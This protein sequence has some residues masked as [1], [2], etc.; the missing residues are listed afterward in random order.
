MNEK[1]KDK[2][3]TLNNQA[4][5]AKK[6]IAMLLRKKEEYMETDIEGIKRLTDPDYNFTD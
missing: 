2:E 5:E 1:I 3:N 6:I 4:N